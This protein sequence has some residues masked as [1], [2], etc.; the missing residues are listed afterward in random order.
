MATMFGLARNESLNREEVLRCEIEDHTGAI[1][2]K[3]ILDI[4]YDQGAH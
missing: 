2:T 3:I 1:G 4:N